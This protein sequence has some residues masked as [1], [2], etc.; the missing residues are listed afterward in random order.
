M[1]TESSES[2]NRPTLA[3]LLDRLLTMD[4]LP[5]GIVLTEFSATFPFTQI[6]YA[7]KDLEAGVD[8][9]SGYRLYPNGTED[10][11]GPVLCYCTE[12]NGSELTV[13]TVDPESEYYNPAIE[14][15]ELLVNDEQTVS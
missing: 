10:S 7:V 14:W 4:T 3:R 1:S 12:S 5:S 11:E 13:T 8:T 6:T 2:K 9:V 15:L